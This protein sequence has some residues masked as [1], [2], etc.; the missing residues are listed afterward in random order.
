MNRI[1]SPSLSLIISPSDNLEFMYF[2]IP[3]NRDWTNRPSRFAVL[4]MPYKY[5]YNRVFHR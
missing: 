3:K 5:L 4:G 2:N 1:H